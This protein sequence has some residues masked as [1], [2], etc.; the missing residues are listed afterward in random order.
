VIRFGCTCLS[1]VYFAPPVEYKWASM[2][3]NNGGSSSSTTSSSSSS[4]GCSISSKST[5]I[6][7]STSTP[8]PWSMFN[9]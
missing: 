8:T 5:T 7:S 1:I 3:R 2:C 4:S 6:I 9:D